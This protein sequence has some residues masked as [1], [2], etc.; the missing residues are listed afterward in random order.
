MLEPSMTFLRRIRRRLAARMDRVSAVE[1]YDRWAATYDSQPENV[2]LTLESPLFS[3]LLARVTVETKIV[4]DIGCG[5]GRH[6]PEILSRSPA[7]LIGVDPSPRMLEQL[8]AHYPDARVICAKGDHVQEVADASCD[9]IVST[10]ALAHIP[11]AASA[12][13]EWC[14]ILRRGGAMLVTDFHPAA[15]RAGMKRTFV[16]GGQ[17]IE[18]EHHAT[19]LKT[20]CDFAADRGLTTAYVVE[21]AIDDWVRPLFERA[22]YLEAYAEHKGRPL[23]FGVHF[24]KP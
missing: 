21:R 10:L 13:G 23:V 7:Q 9:L 1:A 8:K 15:I 14:R 16:S 11:A 19:D 24:M 2:V 22:R 20:L 12:I 3:E 4:V 5:T 18:V 17:T 6:W